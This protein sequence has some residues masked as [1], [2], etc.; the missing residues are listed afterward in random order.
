MIRWYSLYENEFPSSVKQKWSF[1]NLNDVYITCLL[2]VEIIS[3]SA[4]YSRQDFLIKISKSQLVYYI[5]N[6]ISN[7]V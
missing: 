1:A 4:A 5:K 3:T 6:K 2:K 7:L